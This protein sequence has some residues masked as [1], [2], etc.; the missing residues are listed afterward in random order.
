[1]SPK[2][3]AYGSD[4]E[5]RSANYLAKH[6]GSDNECSSNVSDSDSESKPAS[7]ALRVG[8]RGGRHKSYPL[9]ERLAARTI[10]TDSCWLF[11][12]F[13]NGPNGY[14]QIMLDPTSR[15][16]GYAHRVAW[17]L[18]NGQPV[19]ADMR[20][21]HKCDNALCVRPD[22]LRL[23]TQAENIADAI[24]KG[25]FHAHYRTGVRLNG[26]RS[27]RRVKPSDATF[28]VVETF[29]Q[30]SDDASELQQQFSGSDRS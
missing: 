30:P 18:A 10:V 9:A 22:H 14:G 13:P 26:Q 21:L 7:R 19:P 20:I 3:N 2:P 27:K 4:A 23:G 28:Q 8:L 15:K 11:Q 29:A 17:E 25:R 5:A 12:G 24:T 16:R 6:P 1:M